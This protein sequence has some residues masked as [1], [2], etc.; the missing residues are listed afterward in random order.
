MDEE[1]YKCPWCEVV[2]PLRGLSCH[3]SKTH[4]QPSSEVHREVLHGGKVPLCAC[5]CG[6]E[7]KWQ[8]KGFATYASRGCNGF[9]SEARSK[10]NEARKAL[11]LAGKLSS[12]NKGL[13]KET[14]A[15]V[16]RMAKAIRAAVDGEEIS[17]RLAARSEEEKHLHYE[18]ISRSKLGSTPWNVG[19][20]KETSSSLASVSAK[21]AEHARRRFNWKSQPSKIVDTAKVRSDELHLVDFSGYESKRSSLT[22]ECITCGAIVKRSL[23]VL[24]YSPGC[25]ACVGSNSRT[26]VEIYEFVKTFDVDAVLSDRTLIAPMELDVFVPSKGFAIEY[27][28]LYWHSEKHRG[29]DYHQ[30]KVNACAKAGVRLMNIYADDW[31]FRRA[32]VESMIAHRLGRSQARHSAREC[33]VITLDPVRRKAFFEA[34][35]LDGDVASTICFALEK[36]DQIVAALSL[37]KPIT[38][39]WNGYLEVARFATS[40]NTH[41]VGALSRLTATAKVYAEANGSKGLLSYVDGR[42]GD[43]SGYVLAGYIKQGVTAPMFWWTDYR[44]RYNRLSYRANKARCMSEKDVANEAGVARI[45]GCSNSIMTIDF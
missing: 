33:R 2:K 40:L 44:Q 21:N 18:R 20:S 43:G 12:W 15:R 8:Q 14:D 32:I 26:Q 10:A 45:Y 1:T 9:S 31:E 42:V 30:T 36:D 39:R 7:V 4:G 27:N 3:A 16:A 24:R 22:F 25:P 38:P 6:R 17:K 19:L 28:D 5:G 29:R 34:S 11:G 13:R 37:R 23:H 35:H 41:V